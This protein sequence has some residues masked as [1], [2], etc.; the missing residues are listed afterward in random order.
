VK[1][2]F[3]TFLTLLSHWR[4]RPGNF[5]ALFVGLAIAT[6]LWSGVQALN[7]HA[8]K[9]YDRAASMFSGGGA[10]SLAP[11]N[12]GAVSQELFVKL[13]LAGWKV[14]P[15]LEATTL[16]HGAPFQLVGIEPLT[17]PRGVQL[18]GALEGR[19]LAGFLAPPGQTVAAPDT[20][21][22]L[23]AAEGDRIA[24]DNGK[25]LP[26]IRS[27]VHA[28]PGMLT[29]D[30]GVA[31]TLLGRNG[32]ISRLVLQQP[33]GP[34]A[35]PLAA[36]V[37]DALRLLPPGEEEADLQR[38]TE[39]FHLNLT[40]FGLLAFLVGLFI[41]HAAFGLAFEQRLPM[42]RTMRA[43]GVST[44]ALA[45]AL[46]GEVA[47]LALVAGS[48]GVAAGF[49]LASALL[50]NV[51]AS[52]DA[53]YGARVTGQLT[54][55]FAWL[56][57]GLGI[58]LAGALVAAAGGLAK[59]LRLPVLA[60]AQPFAWRQAEQ[61][62]M[63]RRAVLALV[64][65]GGALAAYL[66]G[67]SLYS[68]FAALAGLLLG[69]AL[70]LPLLLAGALRLGEIFARGPLSG[71]FWADSRQQLP[72]LSLALTALL[73]A[74]A[75]NVGVGGMVEGF[76]QTF[77]RWLD[78]RLA[79]EVYFEAAG[80]AQA[81]RIEA[82]LAGRPEVRA[83]LPAATATVRLSGWPT[84]VFGMAAHEETFR[85][86]F[87]MLEQTSDAWDALE[88]GDGAFVSEQ[89]AHRLHLGLGATLDI[90]AARENWRVKVVG[91]FPDYGN[92]KGQ[93]RV[94]IEALTR[95]WPDAPRLSYG[96]RVAPE[97]AAR[98]I[99]DMQAQLGGDLARITDQ[100][101]IRKISTRIFEHTF[102]VTAALNALTLVV[103]GVALLASL[104]TLG[105]IR[106]AQAAPVWACGVPRKKL[107]Q[108]EFLRVLAL[109]GATAVVAVPVG[110]GLAWCLVA[111]VN[112]QAFGWRLPYHVFP[113]QWAEIL[114]LA[115]LVAA[116]AAIAP[117]LRFARATPAQLARI[118]A[119]ER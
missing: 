18:G 5:A 46:F 16:I 9:S 37:G 98:L 102:S 82:W 23:G 89:L 41:V 101:A 71:W 51:A 105:D 93:A 4:R 63:R 118:F 11:A 47:A 35:A 14:S 88:R 7:A 60:V 79:A 74:F 86:H 96:L 107:A 53:L 1:Q 108:L 80:A 94:D 29:V 12:G 39:S 48:V 56:A 54:L 25:T 61:R 99:A 76:R 45:A 92:P 27:D 77:L 36:V 62:F 70:L 20:L 78:Q 69:A 103:S 8:R 97:A 84:G 91:V 119:N 116:L 111:V 52:L 3:W 100:A 90:P 55:D 112:V 83:V 40:A 73:L 21:R 65:L 50:P 72:G 67:D 68:G 10:Q 13:R 33:P 22:D 15:A 30:I 64:A 85:A 42:V 32:Q 31:Q 43:V 26:P 49:F 38:L 17:L 110:L 2:I 81:K 24:L 66:W 109:T 113:W 58:A 44:P 106:L 59:A 34:E 104:S 75:T 6:A 87:P 95:H 115:L 57:S 117:I 19:D 28:P 114:A